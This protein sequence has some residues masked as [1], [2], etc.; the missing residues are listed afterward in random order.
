[1]A[2]IFNMTGELTFGVTSIC[3][4]LVRGHRVSDL[5]LAKEF[6]LPFHPPIISETAPDS[7][8]TMV[9]KEDSCA[10]ERV[11]AS[12]RNAAYYEELYQIRIPTLLMCNE[13]AVFAVLKYCKQNDIHSRF[14]SDIVVHLMVLK[15]E[16]NKNKP[17]KLYIL[18][19]AVCIVYT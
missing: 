1:M 7:S 12:F 11:R 9:F 8:Y 13:C 19:S 10:S 5:E 17:L 2:R 18:T 14:C 16:L 3:Y 4:S 15:S 6:D